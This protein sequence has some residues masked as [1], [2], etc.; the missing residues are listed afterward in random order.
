MS[1]LELLL[2]GEDCDVVVHVSVLPKLAVCLGPVVSGR[3]NSVL[4]ESVTSLL[5]LSADSVGDGHVPCLPGL[6]V[7]LGLAVG[8]TQ[9]RLRFS[10]LRLEFSKLSLNFNSD[11]LFR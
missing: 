3:K 9:T 5:L 6:A 7:C 1:R 11:I 10:R 8:G 2:S 4:L